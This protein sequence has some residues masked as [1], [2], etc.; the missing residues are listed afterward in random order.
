MTKKKR[1]NAKESAKNES[2][3]SFVLA[4]GNIRRFYHEVVVEFKKIVWP[5]RKVTFGLSGF[6]ILLTVLLS[7]YLGA[8]DLILGKL[9]GLVLQ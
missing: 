6:V 9:V 2:G 4:P 5:D 7:V 8:V 1:S 3:S